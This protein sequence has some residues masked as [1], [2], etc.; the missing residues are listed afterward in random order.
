MKTL[1]CN[2]R[3]LGNTMT[4]HTLWG[5][6]R[7]ISLDIVFLMETKKNAAFLDLLKTRINF[8][9]CFSVDAKGLF[10]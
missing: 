1:A 10:W 9:G 5:I 7:R 2:Y 4:I 3:G 6:I 8:D